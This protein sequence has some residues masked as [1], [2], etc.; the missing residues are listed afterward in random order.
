MQSGYLS[1]I[2]FLSVSILLATGWKPV[3]LGPVKD[4]SVILFMVGWLVGSWVHVHIGIVFLSGS[5]IIALLASGI[6][7]WQAT[8]LSQIQLVSVACLIA[9]AYVFLHHLI[10]LHPALFI[11]SSQIESSLLIG[12]MSGLFIQKVGEMLSALTI[13]LL[14]GQ[15]FDSW[16][17]GLPTVIMAGNGEFFDQWW[18]ALIAARV[19]AILVSFVNRS[20]P[21][22]INIKRQE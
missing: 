3:M 16:L 7:F 11:S 14:I 5:L 20:Q 8:S 22:C 13:G 21:G 4:R 6:A 15:T 2:V 18:V 19:V 12:G 10:L 17:N 9:C 1:F